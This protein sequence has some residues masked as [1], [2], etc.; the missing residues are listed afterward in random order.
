[1]NIYSAESDRD[2]F[3]TLLIVSLLFFGFL[4]FGIVVIILTYSANPH[5]SYPTWKELWVF[6]TCFVVLPFLVFRFFLRLC[7]SRRYRIELGDEI[8]ISR[9]GTIFK[10]FELEYPNIKLLFCFRERNLYGYSNNLLIFQKGF[11]RSVL[12]S[13]FGFKNKLEFERMVSD[14]SIS[15]KKAISRTG[16]WGSIICIL[17][18]TLWK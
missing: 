9:Q 4:V 14:I 5:G 15:S 3:W 13:D 11:N 6:S 17:T 1:M 8:K 12:L 2:S 16:F 18:L 10:S 7:K